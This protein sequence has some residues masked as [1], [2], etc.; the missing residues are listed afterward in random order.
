[1]ARSTSCTQAQI[2]KLLKAVLAAGVELHQIAAVKL[3]RDGAIL[4][5]GQHQEPDSLVTEAAGNE[6]EWDEV[7]K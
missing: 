3:T 4:I 6:N 5:F 1:M 2:T 7:L